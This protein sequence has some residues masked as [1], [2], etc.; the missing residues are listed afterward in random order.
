MD[1]TKNRAVYDSIGKGYDTTRR[2]D[3][4]IAGRLLHH[5][6]PKPN[7]KYLELGCGSGNYTLALKNAG[8]TMTGVD[9]SQQ[10]LG[11][12]YQK[13]PS[14]DW[15]FANVES[16]PFGNNVF[17]GASC[18][19][20]IHHFANIKVAF[21]EA[22]RV[23]AEGPLVIFTATAEQMQAYWL[24]EYFPNAMNKSIIQMPGQKALEEALHGAGFSQIVWEPYEIRSDLQDFFLYIGKNRPELYLDARI[25]QGSSTFSSL[26]NPQEVEK[27][28]AQLDRDIRSGRILKVAA[29]YTKRTLGDYMFVAARK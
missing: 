26:S 4:Y 25:R 12:A 28:C 22:A 23:L 9:I 2:A 16:L 17:S 3:P 7:E 19:L 18:V 1:P 11:R 14:I 13:D 24:N 15:V 8:L 29:S 21:K 6:S 27:G 20:A 5:L 10:M